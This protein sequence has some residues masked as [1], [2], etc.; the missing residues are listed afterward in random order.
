MQSRWGRK[1]RQLRPDS[2]PT[3]ITLE[4]VSI[5]FAILGFGLIVSILVFSGEVC[6]KANE[7][8]VSDPETKGIKKKVKEV[9][10]NC[11]KSSIEDLE[12]FS[13]LKKNIPTTSTALETKVIEKEVRE[14]S[15]NFIE[16]SNEELDRFSPLMENIPTVQFSQA[17]I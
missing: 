8:K 4:H 2:K 16:N 17:D 14:E 1:V 7:K 12:G 11:I 5:A 3:K 13:H 6:K 10:Q 15:Q 9:R